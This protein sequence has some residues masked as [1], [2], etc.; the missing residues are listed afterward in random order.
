MMLLLLHA[1][2]QYACISSEVWLECFCV[3]YA[4]ISWF[5]RV[6]LLA[7]QCQKMSTSIHIEYLSGHR[8]RSV[9]SSTNCSVSIQPFI[10]AISYGVNKPTKHTIK[11]SIHPSIHPNINQ[12]SNQSFHQPV[13]QCAPAGL[14]PCEQHKGHFVHRPP[15]MC[16]CKW[17]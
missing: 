3:A 13:H 11:Q 7:C 10:E 1:Y 17:Q 9:L 8:Y 2:E 6:C 16:P 15:W 12:L 4:E 14:Q 5:W